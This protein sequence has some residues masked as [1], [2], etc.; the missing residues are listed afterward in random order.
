MP[1]AEIHSFLASK[2]QKVLLEGP[3]TLADLLNENPPQEPRIRDQVLGLCARFA[4]GSRG[5]FGGKV[6]KNVAG[7]DMSKLFLGS[8]GALGQILLVTLKTYPLQFPVSVKKGRARTS[9]SHEAKKVMS[10]IEEGL[11]K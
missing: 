6:V 3:D 11:K 2:R 8:R 5:N 1:L 9:P 10:R 7:Y 4:D